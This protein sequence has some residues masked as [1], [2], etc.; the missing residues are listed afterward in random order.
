MVSDVILTVRDV[1]LTVSDVILTVSD[2]M[3]NEGSV[4]RDGC[5]GPGLGSHAV[6]GLWPESVCCCDW[7][8]FKVTQHSCYSRHAPPAAISAVTDGD[9]RTASPFSN[10][11]KSDPISA[12]SAKSQSRFE[13]QKEAQQ[14]LQ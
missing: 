7:P 2:V 3:L 5:P 11:A 6:E 9:G 12:K 10:K 1:I 8:S 13:K 14:N 4:W